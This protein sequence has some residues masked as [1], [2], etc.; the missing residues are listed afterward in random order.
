MQIL[1]LLLLPPLLLPCCIPI[2]CPY[3]C[4]C[5]YVPAT[6][7]AALRKTAIASCKSSHDYSRGSSNG[8][9][10]SNNSSTSRNGSSRCSS[11]TWGSIAVVVAGGWQ[12]AAEVVAVADGPQWAQRGIMQSRYI[13]AKDQ[14]PIGCGVALCKAFIGLDQLSVVVRL[15]PG[16]LC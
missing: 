2:P 10:S 11:S 12:R 14:W 16:P 7:T 3:H 5:C 4:Y 9:N 6:A 13:V 15:Y 8:S 1:L